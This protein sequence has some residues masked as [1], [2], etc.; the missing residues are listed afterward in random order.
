MQKCRMNNFYRFLLFFG[1]LFYKFVWLLLICM[2]FLKIVIQLIWLLWKLSYRFLIGSCMTFLKIVLQIR[3]TIT[4]L[5]DYYRFVW[6]LQICMTITDLYYF[7]ENCF[8]NSYDFYRFV[9]LLQICMSFTDLYDYYRFVW[10]LQI[11]W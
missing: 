4:D 10:L 11:V 6:L 9:W 1:K 8:T 7:F 3:M 2:T 5:Y